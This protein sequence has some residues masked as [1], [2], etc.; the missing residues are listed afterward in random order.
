MKIVY[1]KIVQITNT[2][3]FDGFIW[4]VIFVAE[5][6]IQYKTHYSFYLNRQKSFC[7]NV[8]VK[9]LFDFS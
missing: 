4:H 7:S 9:F 2:G 6:T 1:N 8:V 5:E 3:S